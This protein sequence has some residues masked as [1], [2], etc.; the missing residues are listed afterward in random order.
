MKLGGLG[1]KGH[2]ER[3]GVRGA[4]S[5]VNFGNWVSKHQGWVR[6]GVK[7]QRIS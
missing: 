3:L 6:L 7:G 4:R 5:E 1:S 2:Y